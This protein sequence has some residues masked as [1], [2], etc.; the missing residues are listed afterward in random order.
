MQVPLPQEQL[1]AGSAG[2]IRSG[3]GV[4][5][6]KDV[7][8]GDINRMSTAQLEIASTVLKIDNDLNDAKGKRLANN[9]Y[10][11]T[12]R[13]TNEFTNLKGANAVGTVELNGKQ[14]PIFEKYQADLKGIY[15][16]YLEQADNATVKTVFKDKASVY[17]SSAINDWTDHTFVQGSKYLKDE[18]LKEI[19]TSKADAKTHFKS[20]NDPNGLFRKNYAIGLARI[21]ELA[22]Q[23]GWNLDPEKE[24]NG[25][26]VGISEQYYAKVNEYNMD[27]LKNVVKALSESG[28]TEGAKRFVES[29]NPN[30]ESK[31]LNEISKDLTKI[32]IEEGHSKCAMSIISNN[33]NQN[34]GSFLSSADAL[35]CLSS[36]HAHDNAIGGSVHDGE[37]SNE[38]NTTGKTQSEN[39]NSLDQRRSTSKFYQPDS[40]LRLLPQHRTTHLFAIQKLG[41]EK[42]DS[43]YTK[44]KSS[45]EYSE[46]RYKNN[47]KYANGINERIIDKYLS[48]IHI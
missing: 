48:L 39:I 15:E 25:K 26:K 7:V 4:Q 13:L 45:I 43:L 20:W 10:A 47:P 11:E 28:D 21:Q 40:K 34:D 5:P 44:A 32:Q 35:L 19:E 3:P 1:S 16:S 29:L 38:V 30:G 33:G 37:N 17:T 22:E 27:I 6:M 23:E 18:T 41:V 24:I 46:E 12:E 36:N 2:N 9:Y 42:A 31:D 8:T 14:V